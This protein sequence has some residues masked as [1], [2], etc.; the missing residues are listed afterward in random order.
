MVLGLFNDWVSGLGG[1]ELER[2]SV[3]FYLLDEDSPLGRG[4][5]TTKD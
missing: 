2:A 1:M 3:L 5:G 4:G